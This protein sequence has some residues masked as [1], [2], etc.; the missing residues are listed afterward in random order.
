MDADSWRVRQPAFGPK[1]SRKCAVLGRLAYLSELSQRLSAKTPWEC[2]PSP[3]QGPHPTARESHRNSRL[4]ITQRCVLRPFAFVYS[5]R[6]TSC[7]REWD[8]CVFAWSA[9]R[10][11]SCRF[12]ENLRKG[13]LFPACSPGSGEAGG[14]QLLANQY[15]TCNRLI[16]GILR[17]Y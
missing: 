16:T 4:V 8:T 1:P 11:G 10:C 14:E 17:K 2:L 5:A 3:A 15:F 12:F 7:V 9:P 13:R 6:K